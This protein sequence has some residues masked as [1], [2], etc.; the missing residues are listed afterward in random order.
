MSVSEREVII[1]TIGILT[2]ENYQI[3]ISKSETKLP[4]YDG[5]VYRVTVMDGEIVV[6]QAESGILSEALSDVFQST[7]E[8]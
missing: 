8:R 3:V 1:N 4:E 6:T 7:P 2:Q 5:I